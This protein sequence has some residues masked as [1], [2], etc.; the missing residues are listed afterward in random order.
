MTE[1]NSVYSALPLTES[2]V[3][4]RAECFGHGVPGVFVSV[5]GEREACTPRL[6][7]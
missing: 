2:Q 4:I 1:P 5:C 7:S 3:A 6:R